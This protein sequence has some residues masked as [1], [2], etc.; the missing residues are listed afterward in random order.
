MVARMTTAIW[1]GPETT[2]TYI[3]RVDGAI[4]SRTTWA[5]AWTPSSTGLS[6]SVEHVPLQSQC[7][8]TMIRAALGQTSKN[9]TTRYVS[10]SEYGIPYCCRVGASNGELST[11][12]TARPRGKRR[13]E[14]HG[15]SPTHPA[16][17]TL[18]VPSRLPNYRRHCRLQSVDLEKKSRAHGS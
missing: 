7:Y 4:P 8:V 10:T 6:I 16:A 12:L 14:K 1:W 5:F 9:R 11:L 2:S 18:Q 15:M 3:H 17:L 13:S